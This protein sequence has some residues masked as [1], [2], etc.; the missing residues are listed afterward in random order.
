MR[1]LDSMIDL[2]DVKLNKL[3]WE[4]EDIGQRAEDGGQRSL[5]SY[6]PWSCKEWDMT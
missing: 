4:T 3:M 6:S 2:M 5:A 1:W